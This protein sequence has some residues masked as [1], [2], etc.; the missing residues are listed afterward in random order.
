M[1]QLNKLANDFLV[2]YQNKMWLKF[3]KE[4]AN[5]EIKENMLSVI[6][7]EKI[8]RIF[9]ESP[10]ELIKS[11]EEFIPQLGSW[12][13]LEEYNSFF[14]L[15]KKPKKTDAEKALVEK[16]TLEL[17]KIS[18]V[19]NYNTCIS[20]DKCFAY[21]LA[22]ELDCN[23]CTYCNRNY[24][25]TISRDKTT[26]KRNK[27]TRLTRPQFDHWYSKSKHPLL[28]LSVH[29]LI[30]SC[31][32]CNSGIKGSTEF[33]LAFHVHPYV[34]FKDAYTFS[35]SIV[36]DDKYSVKINV[37]GSKMKDTLSIMKLEELYRAHDDFELKDLI[38]LAQKYSRNYTKSLFKNLFKET[39]IDDAEVYRL[40][41]GV[42]T[43][44]H[45]KRVMSKFKHDIIEE[46]KKSL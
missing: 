23:T 29:N 40:I 41:F 16:Y 4:L 31:A 5:S 20:K 26:G 35:Y 43:S 22:E 32:I 9:I 38:D 18:A 10:H 21:W 3:Q 46:L 15:K 14:K 42:D 36:K 28:A 1:F 13:T 44:D 12:N 24:T 39:S 37:S 34:P 17:N 6:G 27:D 11:H 8:K 7:E 33:D 19:F 45:Q 25:F 2:V 30:P